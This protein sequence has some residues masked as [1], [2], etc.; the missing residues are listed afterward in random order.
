MTVHED[1]RRKLTSFPE[2]KILEIKEDCVVGGHYH[3]VKTEY[4]ILS[5]GGA[6]LI[7]NSFDEGHNTIFMQPGE[8]ITIP[9]FTE[10]TFHIK[11]GSVLIGLCS[12]EF[13]PTDDYKI[14]S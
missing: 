8:L 7:T 4:F 10:H 12:H 2:A 6:H 13:D 3:K 9:P 1:N 5:S 14:Q 11:K